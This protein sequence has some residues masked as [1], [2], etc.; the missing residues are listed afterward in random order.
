MPEGK[1][2]EYFGGGMVTNDA[3]NRNVNTA[4]D[5]FNP[6]PQPKP[7]M[8][9]QPPNE[10]EGSYVEPYNEDIAPVITGGG[11]YK[12]GGKVSKKLAKK[13]VKSIV[14]I[15]AAKTA[16]KKISE[17]TK[18]AKKANKVAK[19]AVKK[20][21]KDGGSVTKKPE[22]MTYAEWTLREKKRK[23]DYEKKTGKKYPD[24]FYQKMKEVGGAGKHIGTAIGKGLKKGEGLKKGSK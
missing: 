12:K 20:K 6:N 18:A 13:A 9:S 11:M 4:G 24:T 16:A 23:N 10:V 5:G 17:N 1:E 14:S 15:G 19:E 21:Y 2:N 8:P 7:M 22:P 3:R